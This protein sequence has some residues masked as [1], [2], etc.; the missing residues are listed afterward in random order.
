M[1][2]YNAVAGVLYIISVDFRLIPI[3][4][5][6]LCRPIWIELQDSEKEK[7]NEEKMMDKGIKS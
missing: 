5:H 3:R 7:K 4:C 1:I 2:F 6:M